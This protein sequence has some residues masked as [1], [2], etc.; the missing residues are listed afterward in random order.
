MGFDEASMLAVSLL[1]I[2]SL[3]E[4]WGLKH[5]HALDVYATW[6][7][8]YK[9]YNKVLT[10]KLIFVLTMSI[11]ELTFPLSILYRV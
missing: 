8:V 7:V 9:F 10:M 5:F 3:H 1:H 2:L 6:V 11:I 4:V